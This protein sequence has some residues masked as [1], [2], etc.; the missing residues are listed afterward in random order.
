MAKVES[1]EMK[2]A[3]ANGAEIVGN[4]F[5]FAVRDVE[6]NSFEEGDVFGIPEK[7]QVIR[8]NYSERAE[9][10]IVDVNGKEKRFYPSIM[11]KRRRVV[12]E[13]GTLTDNYIHTT[14]KAAE[15][16]R[17]HATV[18][19]AMEAL[20]GKKLKIT[21][22]DPVRCLRYGTTE[23]TTSNIPVIEYA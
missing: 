1:Q 10:I 11:W 7:F 23:I 8:D 19:E 17:K 13:D 9:F 21:K 14:G 3:L 12:N 20:A 4:K 5:S 15:D 16:F 18:Q 2:R 22:M 6:L